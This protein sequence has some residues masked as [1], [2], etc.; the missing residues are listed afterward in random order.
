MDGVRKL[1]GERL[2]VQTAGPH[3]EAELLAAFTE[4]ALLP[5]ERETVVDHLAKCSVCRETIFLALPN[6]AEM[7][8]VLAPVKRHPRFA[9]RWGTLVAAIAVAAVL[10]VNRDQE[11][12]PKALT[13]VKASAQA[14]ENTIA[15]ENTPAE[16]RA[17]HTASADKTKAA[18]DEAV[19]GR[20]EPKHM[21]AKPSVAMS[22]EDSGQVQVSPAVNADGK[23]E[24]DAKDLPTRGRNATTLAKIPAGAAAQQSIG[25]PI[26]ANQSAGSLAGANPFA[27]QAALHGVVAGMVVDATGAAIPNAK[28][29]ATGP[30]GTKTAVSNSE[31]RFDLDQ[32]ANGTYSLKVEA[33][34]FRTTELSQVAV[35]DNKPAQTRVTL[36]VGTANEMV[37]VGAATVA[38]TEETAKANESV[39]TVSVPNANYGVARAPAQAE[40]V[41]VASNKKFKNSRRAAALVTPTVFKW[42]IG[43]DGTVQRSTDGKAWQTV[44]VASGTKFQAV[45]S[46]QLNV[47]VGGTSGALYHSADSGHHWVQ[48]VPTANGNRLQADITHIEFSDPQNGA[49]TTSAGQVWTTSDG[50]QSWQVK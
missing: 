4:N 29:S 47:W 10:I 2:K 22:F 21:T 49:I 28:V 15:K 32:L 45:S 5:G 36:N 17:M 1:V 33:N 14:T 24:T 11:R 3:P 41:E 44:S 25:G 31:G 26:V 40:T 7:Q 37:E 9:L 18:Y 23:L 8:T 19:N 13:Q 12:K 16:F 30:S 34:G 48:L 43:N 50:G 6:P 27:K 46:V 20:P 38:P 35:L 42:T 39:P